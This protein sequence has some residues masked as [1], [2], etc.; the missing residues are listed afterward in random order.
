MNWQ[1]APR[2]AA[3]SSTTRIQGIGMVGET[4]RIDYL[5]Q[6]EFSLIFVVLRSRSG[7]PHAFFG[8]RTKPLVPRCVNVT[9][10]N[11]VTEHVELPLKA[12]GSVHV[13][14]YAQGLEAQFRWCPHKLGLT[15]NL[16]A[17]RMLG[18]GRLDFRPS[19]LRGGRNRNALPDESIFNPVTLLPR[20]FSSLQ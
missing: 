5:R 18:I 8:G 13:R 4:T 15:R 19:L 16:L 14:R 20:S 11:A 6:Y 17:I 3:L 9:P 2:T 10:N 1:M 12:G 7:A